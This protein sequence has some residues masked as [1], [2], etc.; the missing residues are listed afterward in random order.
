[1]FEIGDL[2]WCKEKGIYVV[3]KFHVPCVVRDV[4]LEKNR[5]KISVYN[6]NGESFNVDLRNFEHVGVELV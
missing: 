5:I 3:T 4:N 2:V 1:M 6:I